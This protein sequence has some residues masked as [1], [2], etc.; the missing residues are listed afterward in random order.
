MT[1]LRWLM[2][3]AMALSLMA[4]TTTTTPKKRRARPR[5][6]TAASQTVTQS[7]IQS[8]RDALA[9]QQQQIQLLQQQLQQRDQQIQQAQSTA[10]EANSKAETASAAANQDTQTVSG[11]QSTVKDLRSNS[12]S[13]AETIQTEQKRITDLENPI[14]VHFRGV[15][16]T[17][18]GYIEA[19]GIYRSH[20][21]NASV[22]SAT[23]DSNIPLQGSA[24]TKLSEFRGDARQ[25]RITLLAETK[26]SAAKVSGYYE[27]DFLGAAPTANQVESNSFNL[28]QRQLWGQVDFDG[29]LTFTGGQMFS[30]ITSDRKGLAT[31][32]EFLPTTI[33]AQYNVGYNW[34]RQLG[35]R[36]TKNFANKVWLAFSVENPETATNVS[37]APANILGLNTSTNALAP[38][39]LIVLNNVPGANGVSTNLA[40]D[41]AVKAVFEPGWGHYEIKGLGRFFRDRIAGTA[42]V[43]GVSNTSYGGG[44][45]ASL[46]LPV[47]PKKLD[48]IAQ[49]L[50]GN[51]I[52]RYGS[53][54]GPDVTI[55]PDGKLVAIRAYQALGG[56]ESHPS[57]KFDVYA[58]LG[59]EYYQRTAYVNPAATS[60]NASGVGYGS[61]FI[62]VANCAIGFSSGTPPVATT[63]ANFAATCNAQSRYVYEAQPGFWYR[64]YRGPKGTLQFGMS[65]SYTYRQTYPGLLGNSF[66]ATKYEPKGIENM[67]MTSFRYVL[68]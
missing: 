51:G 48:I 63:E 30:L 15:T 21:E 41:I 13:T 22:S 39:G 50:A 43:P 38:S 24:N 8:L 27:A 54:V 3:P 45:G 31:R 9:A 20:N 7:D 47:I 57:D 19:A 56:L 11:M 58:Y 53:G 2:I 35:A 42:A 40:P 65:Y 6:K 10:Q 61:P 4:Q 17:P 23:A 18:G 37:N 52:G 26:L 68:P 36:V 1:F 14:S 12:G 60:V 44:I 5:A 16:L 66:T 33:D 28:R 49:A 34:A 67:V 55:R 46:S 59:G 32:A 64:F 62:N 29:G 25:S